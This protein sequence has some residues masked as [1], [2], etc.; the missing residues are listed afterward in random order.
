M[1]LI[2]EEETGYY[3]EKYLVKELKNDIKNSSTIIL[4]SEN[5]RK[6]L[7]GF[8]ENQYVIISYSMNPLKNIIDIKSCDALL[9]SF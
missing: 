4:N 6:K 8:E 2:K 7:E 5:V 1:D 3:I 9:N